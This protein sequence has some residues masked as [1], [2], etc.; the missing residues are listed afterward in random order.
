MSG[1]IHT[2]SFE[3]NI[4]DLEVP[5][6]H[7][8]LQDIVAIADPGLC[9]TTISWI[10]PTAEDNCSVQT[11]LSN[12]SPG[13][14]FTS[15]VTTVAYTAQDPTGNISTVQFNVTILDEENPSIV[16]FP[17]PIDVGTDLDQCGASIA[18]TEPQLLDNCDMG[19]VES[20]FQSGDTFP[21]G[22]TIVTYNI[23]DASGNT[24]S[25]SFTV[26]VTDVQTPQF[27]NSIGS[28]VIETD[29]GECGAVHTWGVPEVLENCPGV[30]MTSSHNPGD[31]FSTGLTVVNYTAT[32]AVGHTSSLMF[33]VVVQDTENPVL[34]GMPIDMTVETELDTCGSAVE[35]I[36]PQASDN[37]TVLE[38]SSNHN[39]G[40]VFPLGTT[41]VSYSTTD[42]S[43]NNATGSFEI[44]IVDQQAPAITNVPQSVTLNSQAGQCGSLHAWDLPLFTDNCPDHQM[45]ASHNPGDY[46]EVGSTTVTFT[47]TDS[48]GNI[49]E[50]EFVVTVV[51]NES[52]QIMGVP[53]DLVLIADQGMCSTQATWE[54]PSSVDNC[55]IQDFTL[56]HTSGMEFQVGATTVEIATSDI[57]GNQT[58][59]A[60]LV[61]VLDQELPQV[62]NLPADISLEADSDSCGATATWTEPTASDN[63]EVATMTTEKINGGVYPV[64]VTPVT[65]VVTDG[66]G[67]THQ[68]TF[69][70]EVVDTTAPGLIGVPVGFEVSND[71]G[72]CGAIVNWAEVTG[73][74]NCGILSIVTT[75]E[76][77]S[78]FEKG[79]T[80]VD[81]LITDLHEN[82]TAVSF[83]VI[84]HDNENPVINGIDSGIVV[85]NDLDQ[86]G[87]VV[88]WEV[89][90][91]ADNCAVDSMSSTLVPGT[92]FSVGS[93]IVTYSALDTSGNG[94]QKSFT[95]T[96]EDA[97]VP[98]FI[99]LPVLVVANTTAGVCDGIASWSEITATDNCQV[100][101]IISSHSSGDTFPLGDTT[102]T[103][104]INDI[105][106]NQFASD[107]TV[108]IEDTEA[109]Q[110]LNMPTSLVTTT[111]L[112][113]CGAVVDWVVP[114]PSD[115]C[116]INEI[117]GSHTP[118]T[119]FDQGTTLVS[120]TVTD[121]SGNAHTESFEVSVVDLEVPVIVSG[122]LD[123]QGISDPG[124]CGTLISWTEPIAEDN[125]AI[126]DFK[127]N[128]Y[129]GEFFEVGT[130]TVS[131]TAVDSTGNISTHQFNVTIEDVESPT[132]SVIPGDITIDTDFNQCTSLVTWEEPSYADNCGILSVQSSISSGSI[133]NLG[134]TT[135]TYTVTD[136][137]GLESSASFQVTVID[138]QLPVFDAAPSNAVITTDAGICQSVHLW[139]VPTVS[140]NCPG[141]E[142][143]S[144]HQPGDL[145]DIGLTIVNYT[146]TDAAGN[147]SNLMFTVI[148]QDEEL[149]LITGLPGNLTIP[150][151]QGACGAIVDWQSPQ[152]SD[153]C[154][155]NS[156]T[157]DASPGDFFPL[158]PS[159]VTYTATD[160]AGLITTSSFMITVED[161]QSPVIT[162]VPQSLTIN[163]QSGQ[164]GSLHAWD[165]PTASDNCPEFEYTSSH[166]PGDFFEI[167]STMVSFT[168]MD[169]S[170]NIT[171]EEFLL[172]VVDNESPLITDLPSNI[173]MNTD[174][175]QCN[176]VVNW[177]EP[178]FSDNCA[179]SSS[180]INIPSGSTFEVGTTTVTYSV[181]DTA[182]HETT[183]SFEVSITDQQVP[184]IEN[185]P[186]NAVLSTEPGTCQVVHEWIPPTVTDNC[187]GVI[188]T[189]SH[190][191]GDSFPLGLNIVTYQATDA[192]GQSREAMFTVVVQDHE[193]PVL[194]GMPEDI[195]LENDLD[196]CGA[197]YEWVEPITTDNCPNFGVS[198][199]HPSG[200]FFDLGMTTVTYTVSDSSG[201]T[202]SSSFNVTVV[203]L[204]LPQFISVPQTVA[205][206]TDPGVCG[207]SHSW[208]QPQI[209]DN[210]EEINVAYSHQPGYV[211]P[212]GETLVTCTAQDLTGNVIS[213]NFTVTVSDFED[214]DF[215]N[216]PQTLVVNTEPGLCDAEVNWIA[217]VAVDN[218][219]VLS[220]S[221][222]H[223]PGERFSI[224][225][226]TVTLYAN[227][228]YGNEFNTSF[229][230]VVQDLE[231]PVIS[232]VPESVTIQSITGF[233]GGAHH[234]SVPTVTDNCDTLEPTSDF[235]S[236]HF[237]PIGTTTVEYSATDAAGNA[238]TSAFTVTV[239]DVEAPVF[240]SIS[241]DY[242][243]SADAD[244]CGAVVTWPEA[245]ASDNCGIESISY[246]RINGLFLELGE[247]PVNVVV[248]DLNGLE[249]SHQFVITV[250]DDSPPTIHDMP[251]NIV[252][253]ASE[254]QC[255]EVV[256]WNE[257]TTTDN[258]PGRLLASNIPSGS[259]F[260]SGTTIVSYVATDPSGNSTTETFTVTVLDDQSPTL[261]G[262]P[263]DITVTNDLGMCGA[264]VS[265]TPA[266]AS[267]NCWIQ[268]YTSSMNPGD[269]FGLGST[270]VEMQAS[271]ASGNIATGSFVVT[272]TESEGPEIVN[273]PDTVTV[274]SDP[275]MCGAI[276]T[277]PEPFA[278][279][280]CA[281][282]SLVSNIANGSYLSVGQHEI[283]YTATDNVAN[284][285]TASFIVEVIDV[286]DPVLLSVP[287]SVQL[288]TEDGA[289]NA[290]V[291]WNQIQA[292]DNC[293]IQEITSTHESG[294]YFDKGTTV[295]EQQVIDLSGNS[296]VHQFEVVVIDN[297][298]PQFTS[299]MTDLSI[300]SNSGVCGAI[301][302]WVEPEISDNCSISSV[303]KSHESGSFFDVGQTM[304]N[305]TLT[306]SSGNQSNLEFMVTVTDTEAPVIAGLSNVITANNDPGSCGASVFWDA[307]IVSD[308]CAVDN[309]ASTHQ[310][311]D[312]FPIGNTVVT[313]S[314]S[315]TAEIVSTFEFM[316]TVVD[317]EAPQFSNLPDL[318]IIGT[319]PGSCGAVVSWSSPTVTDNC[320]V[321]ELT[322]NNSKWILPGGWRSYDCV[323][324]HRRLWK[325]FVR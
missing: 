161:L 200:T 120:Y 81:Y 83:D 239:E 33:T 90:V 127:P 241:S 299:S 107:F 310:P 155:I 272:V 257:P 242:T 160:S 151:D 8:D 95:V 249:S 172:T 222:S 181:I 153:N 162:G 323:H 174:F 322:S 186:Q 305:Y 74:D 85:S 237:F 177:P 252:I 195:V 320:Q 187:P 248:V 203:D 190:Q 28:S 317:N 97:E 17:S 318:G 253:T 196:Q 179:V 314:A 51:D 59:A 308:N 57:H 251:A 184:L 115:N 66:S 303:V 311:G 55:A 235:L 152:A 223:Q 228:I 236:G 283:T 104:T 48:S 170:G 287:S 129:P 240:T 87:A 297:Q 218:C 125:C 215:E 15:G 206:N 169:T 250:A 232:Q 263:A 278:V 171:I 118:G 18:W 69:Q 227:D 36:A 72:E 214:P 109:P 119:Y 282:D 258:C 135:V 94:I 201:N 21:I 110:L 31:F 123:I 166:Q 52:P 295:V 221:S 113:V 224:G 6:I 269:L 93:T 259:F 233:C 137:S 14:S 265:W 46:F 189:S 244:Q 296:V 255:G 294:S 112:G 13:D 150:A 238:T 54:A 58:T 25:E 192:Y 230:I 247:Y 40:D 32:D 144:S 45:V 165:Q 128:H 306:D 117:T 7:G 284:S 44:M 3:V 84:V 12:H 273:L 205:I 159:T 197:I 136:L 176:A 42:S 145:F 208:D 279:D 281:M 22:T 78:F 138:Q 154:T 62:V 30:E 67:N 289:C 275:G 292:T 47:A 98:A 163:T 82:Q 243:V 73:D 298:L 11:F 19:V 293:G 198:I 89:P 108:R 256:S 301:S 210:C 10:D 315:D 53:S 60:F 191:S 300:E 9:S 280:N 131:Y 182:G 92:F 140:E 178:T 219:E 23:S 209:F 146:A 285:T 270:V 324:S 63:C 38:F 217:P 24:I 139:D 148:V 185:T 147:A 100:E 211:F 325:S 49:T 302:S 286:E 64:G 130:T 102:V 274:S 193:N 254:G 267:D 132:I 188:V 2:D 312:V 37:C 276:A 204:Q 70:I 91:P 27:L 80:Q 261:S 213:T 183:A 313:Y 260:L 86:C 319:D 99:D 133:F 194:S 56:S 61:T 216:I 164:C 101:T 75:H 168:A 65:Y 1:N 234:W 4:V 231:A 124:S 202:V 68:S 29:L 245:T 288:N 39:S 121:L 122:P 316:V 20:N 220:H 43:G 229:V 141:L 180:Q 246:D 321:T 309:L 158:G 199:T 5:V 76:P 105:H 77:G 262:I 71:L 26:T 264:Q 50:A 134:D 226:T 126:H 277:W 167:G 111:D 143:T 290:I 16:S 157:S 175:N 268:D 266:T 114:T 88:T 207:A 173:S 291:T 156:F 103:T 225:E 149:P 106:G 271:D 35:W 212:V 96:V 79:T 142:V 307:P 34:T 41:T 116:Q 304:V